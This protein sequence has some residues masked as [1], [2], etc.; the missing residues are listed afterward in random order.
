MTECV[1]FIQMCD[2]RSAFT[3]CLRLGTKRETSTKFYNLYRYLK[4]NCIRGHQQEKG[5]QVD[6]L[7]SVLSQIISL[8]NKRMHSY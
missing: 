7:V 1:N 5:K 3:S 4:G 2:N 8:V 6:F